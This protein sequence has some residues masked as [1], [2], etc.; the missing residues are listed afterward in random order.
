MIVKACEKLQA[1][2]VMLDGL[3]SE[4]GDGDCGSTMARGAQ[5]MY[6]VFSLTVIS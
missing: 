5:C 2:K 1:A 3:D 4:S 6:L